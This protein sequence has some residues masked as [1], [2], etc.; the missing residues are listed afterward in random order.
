M[1]RPIC[2]VS[3]REYPV[4]VEKKCDHPKLVWERRPMKASGDFLFMEGSGSPKDGTV[5]L[6]TVV[7]VRQGQTTLSAWTGWCV[8]CDQAV[9]WSSD[10]PRRPDLTERGYFK[11]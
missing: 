9:L 7:D 1:L 4:T 11:R 8:A 10:K 2:N 5:K 3:A 6:H